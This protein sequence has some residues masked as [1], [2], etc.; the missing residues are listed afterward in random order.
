MDDDGGDGRNSEV[1]FTA[2]ASGTFYIAA[3]A[4]K[5]NLGTCEVKVT[6]NTSDHFLNG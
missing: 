3:G 6:E 5:S 1:T 4:C 2:T